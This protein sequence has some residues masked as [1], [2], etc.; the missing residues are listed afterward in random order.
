MTDDQERTF[1]RIWDTL[2]KVAAQQQAAEIRMDRAD[3]RMDRAD[4]RM[5]RADARMDRF[6]RQMKGIQALVKTGMRWFVKIEQEHRNLDKKIE[7]LVDAQMRTEAK[8]NRLLDSRNGS[9][10][11]R[12]RPR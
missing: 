9:N 7:A 6:D 1:K 3:A 10:G 2:D 5:D 8:L 4:A 11:H 12:K